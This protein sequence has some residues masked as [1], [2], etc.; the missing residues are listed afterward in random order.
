MPQGFSCRK[1]PENSVLL[2]SVGCVDIFEKDGEEKLVSWLRGRD[3]LN[4]YVRIQP[5]K[6]SAF[7]V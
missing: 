4:Y 3:S 7:Y 1:D 6:L 5:G 2:I